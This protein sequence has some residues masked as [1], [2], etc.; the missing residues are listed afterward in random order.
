[1]KRFVFLGIAVA[2]C[3]SPLP[4][5]ASFFDAS[6]QAGINN[7]GRNR[8]MAVV[9]YNQDGWDDLYVCRLDSANL[10][11]RNNGDGTFTDVAA[12]AGVAYT[13]PSTT[14]VWGDL[15][16]DGWPDL[17]L[18][19]F[20]MPSLIYRNNGDGTFT[21]KTPASGFNNNG[22]VQSAMLADVDNDGSLDIYLANAA[23]QNALFLNKGNWTFQ[24]FIYGSGAVDPTLSLGGIFFDYDNDGD[25][26]LYLV[27]DGKIPN[28]LYRNDGKGH[29][30]DVSALAGVNYAGMGMGVDAGDMNNDGYLD[31][32]ITNLYENALFLNNGNGKFTNFSV[33]A[34]VTDRGMGWGAM[35][36][37]YDNDC[38]MDI[39]VNNDTYFMVDGMAY[40]NLLYRNQGNMSF[41]NV[42]GGSVVSSPYGGYGVAH[43]DVNA[44]G[45]LDIAVCNTGADG[46][47]LFINQTP[48]A[49]HWVALHLVGVQS[50]RS[51]IGA[52]VVLKAGGRTL[53][54]Q[55]IA[56]SGYCSQNTLNLHFGLQDAAEVD[57]V[58]VFWPG[59]LQETF[60]NLKADTLH[61][62]VEGSTNTATRPVG[63]T[64]HLQLS[65]S[66]NPAQRRLVFQ[67]EASQARQ[68]IEIRL[69]DAQGRQVDRKNIAGKPAGVYIETW[70]LDSGIPAGVYYLEVL[71]RQERQAHKV[72]IY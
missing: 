28:L 54:D 68:E 10:L 9:D 50:N 36:I 57:E 66:P 7:T 72:V 45:L 39:Y 14:S 71:T 52:R 21:N 1:M 17:V 6:V 26:D 15:D 60:A 44:D 32:Y 29:F 8:G 53:S 2:F 46:N 70:N 49:Y 16:N 24:N 58:K 63:R 5:Q 22:N 31:L 30:N 61:H 25:Q 43:L 4:A 67:L 65:V 18:G 47:Q 48:D 55:V 56:G 37:D 62:L 59:G 33:P 19:N 51:A 11:Y 23:A 35:W 42:A 69:L 27:H 38:W 20:N 12:A 3:Q 64:G 34:G 40:N 13:G 41:Q